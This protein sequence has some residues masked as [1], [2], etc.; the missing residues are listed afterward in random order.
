MCPI[1]WYEKLK[2]KDRE[3]RP[4]ATSVFHPEILNL[5]GVKSL[6]ICRNNN[7]VI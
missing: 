3:S 2:N 4:F 1:L 5:V 7:I 6:T